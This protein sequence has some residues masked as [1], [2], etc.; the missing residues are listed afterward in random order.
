MSDHHK[1]LVQITESG[2][3]AFLLRSEQ[4][5]TLLEQ[6]LESP[7][8]LGE[9][10]EDLPKWVLFV[11]ARMKESGQKWAILPALF[12]EGW[13]PVSREQVEAE[14]GSLKT[15]GEDNGLW[16]RLA[17]IVEKLKL[18]PAPKRS[19]D[20]DPKDGLH[21]AIEKLLD[22]GSDFAEHITSSSVAAGL[23]YEIGR[24]IALEFAEERN[25]R[26]FSGPLPEEPG[27]GPDYTKPEDFVVNL[28]LRGDVSEF[29][30][31]RPELTKA[32]E[33]LRLKLYLETG[34]PLPEIEYLLHPFKGPAAEEDHFSLSYRR[35]I[36]ARG[37]FG[38]Q[39]PRIRARTV[40]KHLHK[41]LVQS[42]GDWL[43]FEQTTRLVAELRNYRPQ[44]VNEFYSWVTLK[45]LR[46]VLRSLLNE[47]YS[48]RDLSTICEFLIESEHGDDFSP[49]R[50]RL[51]ERFALEDSQV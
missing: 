16:E 47:G 37:L 4:V 26:R 43:T 13:G 32:T 19:P 5:S 46:N 24:L 2:H 6:D 44:L 21:T 18:P 7:V 23:G 33:S 48:I 49:L 3:S 12:P 29:K 10:I 41:T 28:Y 34:Y 22:S 9:S 35:K 30:K 20:L 42:L 25:R 27:F 1:I 40:A 45:Q 39:N 11:I 17:P 51:T 14:L 38:V 8:S 36:L 31:L 50:E 15:E